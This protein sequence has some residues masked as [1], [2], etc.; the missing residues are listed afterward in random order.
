MPERHPWEYVT[1]VYQGRWRAGSST[2][3]VL[4]KSPGADTYQTG[5]I[6]WHFLTE[7]FI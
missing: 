2:W 3:P 4:E 5:R 1:I 7:L 6:K